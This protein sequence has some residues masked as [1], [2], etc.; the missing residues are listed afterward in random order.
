[1]TKLLRTAQRVERL[2]KELEEAR[3]DL[4]RDL[5]LA[6]DSGETVS[7]LARRL[8]LSRARIQQLLRD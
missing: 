7:G 3:A 6:H 5:R 2:T 1:M 8:N 4:R